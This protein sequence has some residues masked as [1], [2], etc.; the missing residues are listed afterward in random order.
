MAKVKRLILQKR[1]WRP[2]LINKVMYM[3]VA[4]LAS[5]RFV[6]WGNLRIVLI[7]FVLLYVYLLIHCAVS[8][9]FPCFHNVSVMFPVT[10]YITCCD[11]LSLGRAYSQLKQMRWQFFLLIGFVSQ[12]ASRSALDKLNLGSSL[13]P[14]DPPFSSCHMLHCTCMYYTLL[15]IFEQLSRHTCTPVSSTSYQPGP[16]WSVCTYF[17]PYGTDVTY[18]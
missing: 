14:K 17:N 16:V 8:I 9:I 11:I 4:L 12:T 1:N 15:K 6:L 10:I 18:L 3:S 2:I 13:L 7:S 5:T